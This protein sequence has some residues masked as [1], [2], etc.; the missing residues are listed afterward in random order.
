[1]YDDEETTIS[2]EQAAEDDAAGVGTA[3]LARV[4]L[5]ASR[6]PYGDVALRVREERVNCEVRFF[7]AGRRRAFWGT[8]CWSLRTSSGGLLHVLVPYMESK[9][10]FAYD[11]PA[12]QY[13]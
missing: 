4:H 6:R 11:V 5:R 2:T 13:S 10:M 12:Q 9:H 3:P 1:M 7:F 8:S